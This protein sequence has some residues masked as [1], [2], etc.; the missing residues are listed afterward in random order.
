MNSES[1]WTPEER[2]LLASSGELPSESADPE[3]EKDLTEL[4]LLLQEM[5]APP[6]PSQFREE[7]LAELET[8]K[9]LR[10]KLWITWAAGLAAAAGLVFVVATKDSVTPQPEI[11]GSKP[12]PEN[13][14]DQKASP[15]AS[16]SRSSLFARSSQPK[17]WD[18]PQAIRKR[19]ERVRKHSPLRFNKS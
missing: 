14:P 15:R 11:T 4:S 16:P 10:P 12:P 5:E 7:L 2:A 8:S 1:S 19:L 18:R 3:I 13:D 17:L 9:V 6:L